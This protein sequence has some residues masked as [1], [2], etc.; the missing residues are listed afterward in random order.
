M[1]K[2]DCPIEHPHI[3]A[4]RENVLG[5]HL[6]GLM[7]RND[8]AK[9]KIEVSNALRCGYGGGKIHQFVLMI[10]PLQNLKSY[11]II[12]TGY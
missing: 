11:S 10:L 12:S 5:K 7:D 8:L 4:V 1:I 2:L 3:K 6:S 9:I